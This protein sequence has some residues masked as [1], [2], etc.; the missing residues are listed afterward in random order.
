V[1]GFTK[2]YLRTFE[3][4]DAGILVLPPRSSVA[5]FQRAGRTFTALQ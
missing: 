4:T 1:S 2:L 5:S 3:V